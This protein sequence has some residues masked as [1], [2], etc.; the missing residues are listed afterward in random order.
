M[1]IGIGFSPM[2]TMRPGWTSQSGLFYA[3]TPDRFSVTPDSVSASFAPIRQRLVVVQIAP[4]I[5]VDF[6]EIVVGIAE[7]GVEVIGLFLA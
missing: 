4:L 7:E 5:E 3:V 2:G 1:T 6:E